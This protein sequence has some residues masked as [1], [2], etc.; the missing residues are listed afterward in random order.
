M[1]PPELSSA[2]FSNTGQQVS[3]TSRIVDRPDLRV[4]ADSKPPRRWR[5]KTRHYVT[6]EKLP[7]VLLLGKGRGWL[8]A[9]VHQRKLLKV[10]SGC[11]KLALPAE[12]NLSDKSRGSMAGE[13]PSH[14]ETITRR[15]SPMSIPLLPYACRSKLSSKATQPLRKSTAATLPSH[16]ARF[17]PTLP[18]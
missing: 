12:L 1:P 7:S 15:L 10:L 2:L 13:H 11:R 18:R 3:P 4:L 9:P 16:A 8:H 6:T 14:V 17:S 5:Q